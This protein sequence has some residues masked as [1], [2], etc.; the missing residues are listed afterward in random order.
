M[1]AMNVLTAMNE[2]IIA[3]IKTIADCSSSNQERNA[4]NEEAI[5][6]IVVISSDL[7][8]AKIVRFKR[9]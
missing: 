2:I 5:G 4:L 6:F 9:L 3:T 1:N 8:I 7:V